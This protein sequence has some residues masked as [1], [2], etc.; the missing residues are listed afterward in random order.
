MGS[1]Y[2]YAFGFR[3]APAPGVIKCRVSVIALPVSV[4][5]PALGLLPNLHAPYMRLLG[6]LRGRL[7]DLTRR[8]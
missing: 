2:E 8:R 6:A 1:K 7:R 4:I 5:A 3:T